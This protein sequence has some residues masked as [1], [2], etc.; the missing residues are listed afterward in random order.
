MLLV[1]S[2][3]SMRSIS[4]E[5]S[6]SSTNVI[7]PDAHLTYLLTK[8]LTSVTHSVAKGLIDT[9]SERGQTFKLIGGF[10]RLIDTIE[11]QP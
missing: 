4:A 3:V 9:R 11:F 5:V 1:L 2:P 6:G 10:R 7:I 8:S